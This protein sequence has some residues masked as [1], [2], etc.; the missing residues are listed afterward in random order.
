MQRSATPCNI[1]H[2]HGLQSGWG[3]AARQRTVSRSLH[4]GRSEI[5][6]DH[7]SEV[8]AELHQVHRLFNRRVGRKVTP[9]RAFVEC[10][11]PA[12]RAA[13]SEMGVNEMSE[14]KTLRRG[15]CI[16]RRHGGHSGCAG[17]LP[18]R[19]AA[20]PQLGCQRSAGP[21][22]RR[23]RAQRVV[24]GRAR[25]GKLAGPVIALVLADQVIAAKPN[26]EGA[27]TR[28]GRRCALTLASVRPR[29]VGYPGFLPI[30]RARRP[31]AVAPS[32]ARW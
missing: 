31:C 16:D 3:R 29:A 5:A 2:A 7:R 9:P 10:G 11:A 32:R 15:K 25:R 19:T 23:R 18:A 24:D 20:A 17:Q 12:H 30:A 26:T 28:D 14:R 22:L 6:A 4:V 27:K 13:Q 21:P 8:M 1:D